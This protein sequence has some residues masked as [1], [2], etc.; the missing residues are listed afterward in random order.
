MSRPPG[1]CREPDLARQRHIGPLLLQ[2]REERGVEPGNIDQQKAVVQP[3]SEN[4]YSAETTRSI[5]SIAAAGLRSL[6]SLIA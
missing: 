4:G 6:Q 3:I 5:N 1:P 2:E